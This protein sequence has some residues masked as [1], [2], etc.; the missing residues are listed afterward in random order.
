M[1]KNI[2]KT[3]KEY[4]VH[5]VM[6]ISGQNAKPYNTTAGGKTGT[7][8]TGQMK[9]KEELLH[10]WFAG[11]YPADKPKYVI[12][13]LAEDARSGN[14][15]A[16]PIFREIVDTLTAPITIPKELWDNN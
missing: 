6:D 9:G 3:L 5:N 12:V 13:V 1:D 11:F 10:G 8:Q 7:A 4:M 15:D 14:Q 2:A 16:S